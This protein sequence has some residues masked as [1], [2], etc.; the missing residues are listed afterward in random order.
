MGRATTGIGRRNG[1][2]RVGA[3][4]AALAL[5]APGC[6]WLGNKW[7]ATEQSTSG[8]AA[9]DCGMAMGTGGGGV[10]GGFGGAGDGIGSVG[11]GVGGSEVGSAGVGGGPGA[12]P[13]TDDPCFGTPAT[14]YIDCRTRGLSAVP[15]S[16]TCAAAGAACGP[17]AAHPY[18][19]GQGT[20]QLVFCKNGSPTFVCAYAFTSGDN[21][22]VTY[23]PLGAFW[24][25][26]YGGGK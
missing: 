1:K 3:I 10:G 17:V 19:S 12:Q 16:E 4:C 25:C 23:T 20:G 24:M 8:A 18:K 6:E 5:A 2:A 11:V 9:G 13:Q 22:A 26:S 7:A 15:C 14:Q 21:C